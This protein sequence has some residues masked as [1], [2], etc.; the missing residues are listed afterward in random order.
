MTQIVF[1][2]I[3]CSHRWILLCIFGFKLLSQ[4]FEEWLHTRKTTF[5]LLGGPSF[6]LLCASNTT[7]RAGVLVSSVSAHKQQRATLLSQLC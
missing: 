7:V 6:A 5:E 4:M 3:F 1:C 2:F